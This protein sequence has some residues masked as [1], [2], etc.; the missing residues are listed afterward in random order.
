MR[1]A[2]PHAESYLGEIGLR[3]LAHD[4]LQ[5]GTGAGP[6]KSRPPG[7]FLQVKPHDVRGIFGRFG[8]VPPDP[9]AG[10]L[11]R[12]GL[13]LRLMTQRR[14]GASRGEIDQDEPAAPL[15]APALLRGATVDPEGMGHPAEHFRLPAV[16]ESDLEPAEPCPCQGD[17]PTG[18]RHGLQVAIRCVC[19]PCPGRWIAFPVAG[20]LPTKRLLLCGADRER[21]R[22]HVYSCTSSRCWWTASS[23]SRRSFFGSRML[24][25]TGQREGG[26]RKSRAGHP[27]SSSR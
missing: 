3:F 7:W 27:T 12:E 17:R 14:H 15:N 20:P 4:G 22:L 18:P 11:G 16:E 24:P 21:H 23:A 9:E 8:A 19:K 2:L 1:R 10:Q 5:Y 25:R 6:M 13:A 26:G